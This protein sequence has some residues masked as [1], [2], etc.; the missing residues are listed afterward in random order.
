[1][2]EK[3]KILVVNRLNERQ[4]ATLQGVDPR[5]EVITCEFKDI[6]QYIAETDIL[7]PWGWM[8]IE[9]YFT[10]AHKLRWVQ[11]LSAGVE[12]MIFPELVDSS[13]VLSSARGIHGI[14]VSEHVLAMMLAWTR[15]LHLSVRNQEKKYWHRVRT[16]E[17]YE[18]TVG[19][20]G[21]GSIGRDI[22]K[23]CKALNMRVVAIKQTMSEELFIDLLMAPGELDRLLE[24][25]DY[26]VLALPLTASTQRIIN[27]ERL[28]KMKKTSF[29]I[30]IS[31]GQVIDETALVEALREGRICGAG[32]DVFEEEPLPP[33]HPLWE[34]ENVIITPHNAALSPYYLDRAVALIADNVARFLKGREMLNVIDKEK[35]Y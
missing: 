29:I 28:Q 7:V 32:L 12:K 2:E 8:D 20:I 10:Q 11:T 34:F 14:P 30:N 4:I 5:L 22:A 31:R 1:M 33:D 24:I 3:I 6:P 16:D 23:K 17:L 18:K 35:G 26:V 15:G 21:L 13:V 19:I 9:P 25:S 27:A